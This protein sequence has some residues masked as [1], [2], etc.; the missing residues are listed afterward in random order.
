MMYL[1]AS[2]GFILVI[3]GLLAV[4]VVLMVLDGPAQRRDALRR[5]DEHE[6]KNRPLPTPQRTAQPNAPGT[7]AK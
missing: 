3:G 5:E 1:Q 2:W 7:I 6:R 4:L